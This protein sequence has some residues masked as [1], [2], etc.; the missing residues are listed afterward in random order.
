MDQA[1]ENGK[2]CVSPPRSPPF[3]PQAQLHICMLRSLEFR[4][5]LCSFHSL[6]H[7]TKGLCQCSPRQRSGGAHSGTQRKCSLFEGVL[8]G[9]LKRC[10]CT[11]NGPIFFFFFIW[12]RPRIGGVDLQSQLCLETALVQA[13]GTLQGSKQG[14]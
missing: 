10:S 9:G 14:H 3:W 11:V 2:R 13:G 5:C 1:K 4:C 6:W 7:V 12:K 8:L